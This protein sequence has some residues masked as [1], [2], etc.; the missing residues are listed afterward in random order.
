MP[1]RLADATSPYLLQHRDNPVDWEVWGPEALARAV[2]EDRPILVSIGYSACHWCHVM[3]HESFEDP[4]TAELMNREFVCVKVDREERPDVD[5]IY[6]QAVQAMTGHGGW[7][8]NAFLTPEGVPFFG[9]T[10]WPPT[11]RMGMPAFAEVLRSV[12]EAWRERRDDVVGNAE[13]LRAYLERVASAVPD[14]ADLSPAIL[15]AAFAALVPRFDRE[16]GGFGG[17]PKFPQPAILDAVLRHHHRTGDDEA[18]NIIRRTLDA[19]ADGGIYDQIGGGFARYSVDAEWLVPH[20][21]KMAYDNAQLVSIYLDAHRA[22]GETRYR[23][24]VEETLTYVDREM[25][26][27]EGGFTSAQDADSEGEEGRFYVWDPG[28]IDAVLGPEDGRVVRAAFGVMAGGNFE[29]HSILHR[30]RSWAAVAAELGITADEVEA[31]VRSARPRLYAAR[32]ERVW[33][34]RDDKVLLGW[35][36][37][38]LRAFADAGR[39][40]DRADLVERAVRCATFL[41]TELRDADGRLTRTWKDGRTGVPAFLDDHAHLIDG[42][43]ALAA[44]TLDRRWLDEAVMVTDEMVATFDDPDSPLFFDTGITHERLITRPRDLQDGATPA[45]NSVAA[46][47]L[48]RVATLTGRTDYRDRA[49]GILSALAGA[50]AEHPAAFGRYLAALD[51]YL[52]TPRE[53]VLAG[54]PAEPGMRALLAVASARYDPHLL[55]ARSDPGDPTLAEAYPILADRPR[56]NDRPTAY[57]CERMVCLPPVTDPADLAI[58]LDQGTAIAWADV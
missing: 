20:F 32:A 53:L 22:L 45:G 7:P 16:W 31:T 17:A 50:M 3:A 2:A 4:A 13:Q 23:E 9:G 1:N 24:V 43:L 12:A 57:L 51:S 36:G 29:G 19:M 38:M 8:L 54:E 42:L 47:V 14:P 39:A 27:P 44:A 10:Y 15:D 30:P 37:M 48:V 52:A 58:Q 26:V 41:L 49:A 25:S 56:R 40:L 5:G 33:P 46:D 21:E 11:P 35:N 18:A 28:E 6:M 34:G 55:I